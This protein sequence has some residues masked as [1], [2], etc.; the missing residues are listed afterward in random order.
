MH[1]DGPTK[2][3][4]FRRL[5][6]LDSK[7]QM[8]ILLNEFQELADSKVNIRELKYARNDEILIATIDGAAS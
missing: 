2:S 3:F 5:R 6:Y 7:W 1:S 8:Y 4:A